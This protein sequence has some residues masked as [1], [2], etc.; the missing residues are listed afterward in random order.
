[1]LLV[2]LGGGVIES[3]SSKIEVGSVDAWMILLLLISGIYYKVTKKKADYFDFLENKAEKVNYK[4]Y[5][6]A[7]AFFASSL[8]IAHT[9]KYLSFNV[10]GMDQAFVHQALVNA[11]ETPILRCDTCN[12][13]SFMGEHTSPTLMLVSPIMMLFKSHIMIFLLE[14]IIMFFSL[15]LLISNILKDKK[16]L[17]LLS[18]LIILAHKSLKQAIIWD[19]REDHLIFLF[20]SLSFVAALKG[21]VFYFILAFLGTLFSKEH[22]PYFLPFIAFPLFFEKEFKFSK[23]KRIFLS[24]FVILSSVVWLVLIQKYITPY[25]NGGAPPKNHIVNRFP[26]FGSTNSEVV[27]NILF[28]PKYWL[29]L[30]TERVLTIEGFKY[31]L[32]LFGPFIIFI[33][34]RW[35]WLIAVSPIFA[36]NLLSYAHTQRSMAFHYDL[37]MLPLL[38]TALLLQIRKIE[39]TK[40]LVLPLLIA[41]CFSGRWP[42][43]YTFKYFP[44]LNDIQDQVFFNEL[45]DNK[46]YTT[47]YRQA[48]QISHHKE[49]RI[50]AKVS[51]L[52]SFEDFIE[53]NST[54]YPTT[55]AHNLRGIKNLI[56]DLNKKEQV[57]I[58]DL[59][60][61]AGWEIVKES[62]SKRFILLENK[63]RNE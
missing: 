62:T 3:G 58:K 29:K 10:H 9:F 59:A 36:M 55:P 8:F 47:D 23:K 21:K 26:G 16:H 32:F 54:F 63:A 15:H 45:D 42:N 33:W 2:T 6:I 28:V 40:K 53:K 44:S 52:S 12:Y 61:D 50:F 13:G 38:I 39:S 11:F 34:R 35:W 20:L 46:L 14:V 18:L 22:L 27:K 56:I 49:Q 25:F 1:M 41:L 30:L 60:I 5:L 48:A 4:S 19:F 43:F 37:A 24:I 31:T 51:N 17:W 57:Q 7:A